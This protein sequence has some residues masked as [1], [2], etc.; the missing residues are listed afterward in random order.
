MCHLAI[1][2]L[3]P[4]LYSP[5][6]LIFY[7]APRCVPPIRWTPLHLIPMSSRPLSFLLVHFPYHYPSFLVSASEMT[8]IVSSG[9][10]NS[11]HSLP[12]LSSHFPSFFSSAP[13]CSQLGALPSIVTNFFTSICQT[14][15]QIYIFSCIRHTI[16]IQDLFYQRGLRCLTQT[17]IP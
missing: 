12:S 16:Q 17:W 11:T 14:V 13:L 9:A 5:A 4:A 8:Y 3:I 1:Y 10:L 6:P 15:P 7:K 2:W